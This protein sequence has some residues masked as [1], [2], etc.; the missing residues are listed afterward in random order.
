MNAPGRL[1]SSGDAFRI[2]QLTDFHSDT[3]EF[4]NERT[5]AMV[6]GFVRQHQPD[7]LAVTGDIW[8]G[9]RH[10]TAAPMYRQRDL[11]F[12]ASLKTPWAFTWGN[13]DC[14][15]DFDRALQEIAATPF[16]IAPTGNGRG[17]FRIEVFQK[18]AERPAWDLFFLNSGL[19]WQF[20]QDAAWIT[21]EFEGLLKTRNRPPQ[22]LLFF[23]IPLGNYH[24]AM[25]EG[26]VQ[27]IAFEEVLCWGDEEGH[28]AAAIRRLPGLRACFCG[29]SHRND[30]HFV[31]EGIVFA[32][33]RSTGFGGYGGED[34]PK[35]A[36]LIQISLEEACLEFHA[37]APPPDF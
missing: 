36:T 30:F 21:A 23:H 2:L 31:E 13:H 29:H 4:E 33:G 25:M 27:G 34:V 37:V 5:R 9:D 16:A 32:Y 28:G 19:R 6:R 22:A 15:E 24:Q 10:T 7:F 17:S 8:C 20:P 14:M 3:S 12:L 11:A 18:N 26:R 35:G 1:E